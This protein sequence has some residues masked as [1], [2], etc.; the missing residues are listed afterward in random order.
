MPLIYGEDGTAAFLRL[1]EEII[2]R[3][4]D[5]TILA[6]NTTAYNLDTGVF[7]PKPPSRSVAAS[8]WSYAAKLLIQ[9]DHPWKSQG[10]A[11]RRIVEVRSMLLAH[12]PA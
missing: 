5:P 8:F 11:Q 9:R 3:C 10:D 1:Q 7:D 2:R 12:G 6:W 4:F